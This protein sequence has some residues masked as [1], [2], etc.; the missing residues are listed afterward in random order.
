[1]RFSNLRFHFLGVFP[2]GQAR[3][4]ACRGPRSP[5]NSSVSKRNFATKYAFFGTFQ[6]LFTKRVSSK[7]QIDSFV[8]FEKCCK[9]RI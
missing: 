5:L 1:M 4:P 6:N 3:R 2:G 7:N 9:M 8:D